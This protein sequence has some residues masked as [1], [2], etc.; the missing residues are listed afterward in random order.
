MISTN[1]SEAAYWH[2]Y[3]LMHSEIAVAI[4]SFYILR[5]IHK[6]ASEG[7]ENYNKINKAARVWSVNLYGLQTAFF[8]TVGRIF[9]CSKDSH[10]LKRLFDETEKHPEYFTKAALSARKTESGVQAAHLP[11]LLVDAWEPTAGDLRC[12]NDLLTPWQQKY[13]VMYQPIRHKAFA[14]R[15]LVL[16]PDHLFSQAQISDIDDLLYALYDSVECLWSLYHNGIKPDFGKRSYDF[17][18]RIKSE[19]RQMVNAL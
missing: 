15:D 19:T 13:K 18:A 9:D 16:D 2:D 7:T 4:D 8:I 12:F 3:V 17:R 6:F 5:E 14:H 10:S 1:G 11:A